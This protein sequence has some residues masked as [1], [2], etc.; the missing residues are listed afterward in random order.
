VAEA[1]EQFGNPQEG[2][3]YQKTGDD[4]DHYELFGYKA[5]VKVKLSP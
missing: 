4:W 5:K 3:R 2:S 1:R